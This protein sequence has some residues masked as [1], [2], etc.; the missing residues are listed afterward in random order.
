MPRSPQQIADYAAKMDRFAELVSLNL[1]LT[2][3]A[4]RLCITKGAACR[5]MCEL[6][7]KYG[8]Q[9]E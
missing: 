2:A 1:P 8:W 9:A 6:R 5:M 3:V 7:A 4:E